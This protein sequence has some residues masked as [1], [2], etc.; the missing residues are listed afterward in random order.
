M[1]AEQIALN[2]LVS[3]AGQ[4]TYGWLMGSMTILTLTGYGNQCPGKVIKHM[5]GPVNI[6]KMVEHT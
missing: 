6:K 3:S 4:D 1:S 5:Y 2:T